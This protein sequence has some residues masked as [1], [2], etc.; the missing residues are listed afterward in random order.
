MQLPSYIEDHISQIPALQLFLKM[1]YQYIAP[2]E[3]MELV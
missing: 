2:E 1:G 3:A